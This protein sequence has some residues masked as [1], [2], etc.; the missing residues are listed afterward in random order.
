LDRIEKIARRLFD[1]WNAKATYETLAGEFALSE[2][3][4]AYNVQHTLQKLHV[5]ARGAIAGR[6]IALSSKA[7]QDMIGYDQPIA[8]AIFAG[9]VHASP[10]QI[11]ESDFVR[12]GLEFEL[13]VEM[14]ADIAP[15]MHPH[16]AQSVI[17]LIAAVRPCFELVEDRAADYSKL[18]PYTLLADNAWCGGIVLGNPLP[19]WA[20]L[21][22][23]DIPSTVMQKG[24]EPEQANTGAADPLGSLAW[25]LNHLNERGITV[26]KGEHIITGSAVRTR[27]P[28]RGDELTYT[29][30]DT[31]VQI[32]VV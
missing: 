32:S 25:V 3:S 18:D 6:K 28:R 21:D 10:A 19:D 4:E 17:D 2:T 30:Q 16:T 15:Q 26:S 22:L 20:E 27:F 23:N 13:A 7:M 24:A 29:I 1:N 8:G 12:L 11:A 31:S 9:D 5:P 14:N